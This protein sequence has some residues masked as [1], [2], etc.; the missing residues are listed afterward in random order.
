MPRP[1]KWKR[2]G[3]EIVSGPKFKPGDWPFIQAILNGEKFSDYAKRTKVTR[4]AVNKRFWL[5]VVNLIPES[6]KYESTKDID[7]LREYWNKFQVQK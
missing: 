5:T 7:G 2:V 1:E 3:H 4:Q 6:K